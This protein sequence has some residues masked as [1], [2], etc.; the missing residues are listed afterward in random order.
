MLFYSVFEIQGYEDGTFAVV[1]DVLITTNYDEALAKLYSILSAA[2]V[3][4]LPYHEGFIHRSDGI[5]TDG[6]VFDR[7][8]IE[9]E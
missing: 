1:P 7:R 2:A 4:V 8:V 6:R 3:S 9:K 5:N